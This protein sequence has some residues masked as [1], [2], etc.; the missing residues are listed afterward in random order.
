MPSEDWRPLAMT[1]MT[2]VT[3]AS[4]PRSHTHLVTQRKQAGRCLPW[5]PWQVPQMTTHPPVPQRGHR[6][7]LLQLGAAQNDN[8][9]P[10]ASARAPPAAARAG[11]RPKRQRTHLVTQ[12]WHRR[13]LLKLAGAPN[14]DAEAAL[15][16][17]VPP[18]LLHVGNV[19]AWQ[20]AC[21]ARGHAL[22]ACC[23]RG[24]ALW[25][26]CC[27]RGRALCAC[28][29][30]GRALEACCAR[31]RAPWACC[32]ARGRALWD[33]APADARLGHAAPADVHFGMLRPRT[34]ALGTT[35]VF[36]MP[37][38]GVGIVTNA[39]DFVTNAVDLVTNAVDFVTNAVDFVK[40]AV[41]FVKNAVGI[42]TNVSDCF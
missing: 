10:G 38:S 15:R 30:R 5:Q 3:A 9:P 29:A 36:N 14:D 39:V 8:A 37:E 4:I 13:Q 6:R 27:A 1:A 25:A 17:A 12:R 34:R 18:R 32:C 19:A 21:C 33:A 26:C 2:K 31:G 24:R 22:W 11:G 42:I 40:N 28:C 20:W 35:H 23:P 41:D 16:D 7:Q